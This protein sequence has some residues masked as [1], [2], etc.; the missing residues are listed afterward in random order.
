[1]S[2]YLDSSAVGYLKAA[3]REEREAKEVCFTCLPSDR[4]NRV[5]YAARKRHLPACR[6]AGHEVRLPDKKG[7]TK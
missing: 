1:M 5:F 3:L 6:A 4:A 2:D 7:G